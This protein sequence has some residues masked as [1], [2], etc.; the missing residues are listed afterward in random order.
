MKGMKALGGRPARVELRDRA[1]RDAWTPPRKRSLKRRRRSVVFTKVCDFVVGNFV[2][3]SHDPAE[4]H[5]I[6]FAAG[7]YKAIHPGIDMCHLAQ[8]RPMPVR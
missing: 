7:C 8:L 4:A 5:V 3:Q 2:P 6:E 1:L